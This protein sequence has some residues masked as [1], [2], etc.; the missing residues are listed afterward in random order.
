MCYLSNRHPGRTIIVL[1]NFG[2]MRLCTNWIKAD[3]QVIQ[4][5][6]YVVKCKCSMLPRWC[7][8]QP[9]CQ[10]SVPSRRRAGRA[11][12]EQCLFSGYSDRQRS[13]LGI[14]MPWSPWPWPDTSTC[15]GL[16]LERL[17]SSCAELN[18][19]CTLHF[20]HILWSI[21]V[22]WCS[23]RPCCSNLSCSF[24]CPVCLFVLSVCLVF[25]LSCPAI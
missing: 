7:I 9:Q 20:L 15:F 17:C 23:V 22:F 8:P 21:T 18:L 1:Y 6:C 14:Y 4:A 10:V 3:S 12:S 2:V 5:L 16:R 24:V 11:G 25:V 19:A 13:D